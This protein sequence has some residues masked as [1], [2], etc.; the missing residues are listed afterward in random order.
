MA[1]S[2]QLWEIVIPSQT[3]DEG[4]FDNYLF[5]S[6]EIHLSITINIIYCGASSNEC[7]PPLNPLVAYLEEAGLAARG[8]ATWY[9]YVRAEKG[10]GVG[11]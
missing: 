6:D 7:P 2:I 8:V 3:Q 4:N 11:S 9:L 5:I 10:L 1:V